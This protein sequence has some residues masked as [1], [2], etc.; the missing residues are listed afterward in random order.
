MPTDNGRTPPRGQ[1]DT[2]TNEETAR[3]ADMIEWAEDQVGVDEGSA[4]QVKYA[5]ELNYSPTL[6][7]CSIF[8][9]YGLKRLKLPL[10]TNPAYSGA[11]LAWSGGKRISQD[12]LSPGD[13]VV[14]DWG[15]GGRTDHVALY[16]GNGLTIGG[17]ESN[18]VRKQGARLGNAVGFARPPYSDASA[19]DGSLD[20][21]GSGGGGGDVG[22]GEAE[23]VAKAAAFAT[24]L[25]LPGIMDS[26]ESM[27]LRGER[28]LMND[29]PLLPFVQQLC[30]ASLRNFQSLPNGDFFAF[31][32]D[33]FGGMG[34]RTPYWDIDDIE[35]ID[36]RI[37]LSDDALA[38]H[39]YVVGDIAGLFNGID[40]FDKAQS[41]GVVTIFNAFLADFMNPHVT[42]AQV[43]AAEGNEDP[44][45]AKFENDPNYRSLASKDKAIA[46]LKKYGARPYFEAVP[47]V[48]NPFYEAFLAYQKFCLLWSR[49]FLSHFTLT[50][51]PEI[52]PGGIVA[53]PN[54]GIQMYVDEVSHVFDYE[55]GFQTLVNF[56]APASLPTAERQNVH[57]GM[58]RAGALTPNP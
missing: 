53:F 58:I 41:G 44:D 5:R 11:W 24:Y 26:L 20:G 21:G 17:N 37:D 35:I 27:S 50:F 40:Y 47:M 25:N 32:P 33:Y 48:R 38:T 18:T 42:R 34:H 4:R 10:P 54:H 46:F 28:S 55:T 29:Q 43:G 8:I 14:Y 51:M 19:P 6:P 57:G 45:L 2:A 15:D 23:R 16:I 7:W 36:G 22:A 30:E 56:S 52:F 49:Q 13:I 1:E 39:V 9:A 12:E 3:I 31:Y